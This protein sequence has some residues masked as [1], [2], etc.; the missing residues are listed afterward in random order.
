MGFWTTWSSERCC[1]LWQCVWTR[2]SLKVRSNPNHSVIL[3]MLPCG[4]FCGFFPCLWKKFCVLSWFLNEKNKK[5]CGDYSSQYLFWSSDLKWVRCSALSVPY[6]QF[7]VVTIFCWFITLA[8][9]ELWSPN[10]PFC[11]P[12]FYF[13]LTLLFCF[14]LLFLSRKPRGMKQWSG[15]W[16]LLLESAQDW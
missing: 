4:K 2:W 5:M 9:I 13:A 1:C 8:V 3:N 12:C 10:P 6:F 15:W 14:P 16:F 7:A 11:D